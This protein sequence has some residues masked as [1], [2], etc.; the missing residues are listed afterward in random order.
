MNPFWRNLSLFAL[1]TLGAGFVGA[2]VNVLTGA[3]NSMEGLGTLIWLVG[4]LAANLGLRAFGGDGW[5]DFGIGF[6]GRAAWRS[7]LGAVLIPLVVTLGVLALAVAT[8]VVK[9]GNSPDGAVALLSAVGVTFAG[10]AVKNIF[11][12]FAWRGY[13]TPRLEALGVS[14][15][16]G[17]LITGL[18][19]A[20]WHIPY[21]LFFLDAEALAQH[22]TL[23]P[24]ALIA[25]ATLLLPLQAIVYGE[26]RL[27]S[28][29][30]WP[31]WLMHNIANAV[32]LTLFAG[33][34]VSRPAGLGLIL[35]PGTE[36]VA[37]GLA[38]GLIGFG[39]YRMRIRDLAR[40][41][42]PAAL[43]RLPADRPV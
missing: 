40:R 26:L 39:L 37:Y 18:I 25:L 13:L 10:S 2:G 12:E 32:S 7:Y 6:G 8:G 41:Q 28:G 19:W 1:V 16:L 15:P 24:V 30:V 27:Q 38:L 29:S 33:G 31:A 4:P 21:Y 20:G 22:T 9:L 3:E 43:D 36:G 17:W 5:K 11:E 34:F 35:S 23:S 14:A 42:P